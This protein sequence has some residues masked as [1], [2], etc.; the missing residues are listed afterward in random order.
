MNRIICGVAEPQHFRKAVLDIADD[1]RVRQFANDDP[2]AGVTQH[3]V[4]FGLGGRRGNDQL[5]RADRRVSEFLGLPM[6]IWPS[7]K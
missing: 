1:S 2:F 4:L 5:D 6:L 7:S 3:D